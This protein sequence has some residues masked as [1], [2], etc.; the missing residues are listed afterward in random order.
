MKKKPQIQATIILITVIIY[1]NIRL[2]ILMKMKLIL[3]RILI[4]KSLNLILKII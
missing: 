1:L 4:G 3:M 2:V